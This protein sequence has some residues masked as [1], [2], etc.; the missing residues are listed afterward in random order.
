LSLK[1]AVQQKKTKETKDFYPQNGDFGSWREF[2]H[3]TAT[4]NGKNGHYSRQGLVFVFFS[5]S[6][7]DLSVY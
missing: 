4:A 6:G 5:T 1:S 7:S 3:L 2:Q